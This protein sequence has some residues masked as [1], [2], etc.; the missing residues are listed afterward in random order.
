MRKRLEVFL[1]FLIFG[2]IIGL[3][4][5]IIA[6]H[7][8]SDVVINFRAVLI[9]FLVVVPFAGLGELIVDQTRIISRINKIKRFHKLNVFLEFFIFGVV[10]G[11][12]EDLIVIGLVTGEPITLEVIGIVTLVTLPFAILGE[13]VVDRKDWARLFRKI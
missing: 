13:L 5:N 1:E 6:L 12:V 7:F 4:E 10:M 2:V 9:A 3:V 8:A 11:V